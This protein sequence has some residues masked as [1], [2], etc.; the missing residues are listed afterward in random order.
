[1]KEKDYSENPIKFLWDTEKNFMSNYLWIM[2]MVIGAL[3]TIASRLGY[4]DFSSFDVRSF[5]MPTLIG[6]GLIIIIA[7]YASKPFSEYELDVL[8]KS[9][10]TGMRDYNLFIGLHGPYVFAGVVFLLANLIALIVPFMSSE[11]FSGDYS[12]LIIDYLMLVLLGIFSLFNVFYEYVNDCYFARIRRI[13]A[14]ELAI[15]NKMDTGIEEAEVKKG[16]KKG[17][18]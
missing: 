8:M 12:Y 3:L 6:L 7:P 17:D 15:E 5:R 1:M 9:K 16:N 2:W 11:I 4:L 13:K 14:E 10:A 18:K